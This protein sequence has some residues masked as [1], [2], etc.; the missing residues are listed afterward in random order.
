[1][2]SQKIFQ[3]SD[4]MTIQE[5]KDQLLGL[6]YGDGE[7]EKIF[8]RI[9]KPSTCTILYNEDNKIIQWLTQNKAIVDSE[10]E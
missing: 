8:S 4:D 10:P 7:P 5:F 1:V 9:E 6:N 3:V 2:Y